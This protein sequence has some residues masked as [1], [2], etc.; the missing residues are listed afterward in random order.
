MRAGE[1]VNGDVYKAV[2]P[3]GRAAGQMQA[4]KSVFNLATLAWTTYYKP[5]HCKQKEQPFQGFTTEVEI[6]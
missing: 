2:D 6:Q 3:E 4:N 5:L 1:Q